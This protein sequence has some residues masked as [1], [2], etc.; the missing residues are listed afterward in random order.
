MSYEKSAG[1]IIYKVKRDGRRV[2]PF[3]LLLRYPGGY[4]EFARGHVEDGEREH[5]T[6]LR[7]IREETG[8][9]EL[10]FL[11]G[12]REKYRFHFKRS[13][14]SVAKDAVLY[15][16]EAT[17]WNVQVSEE[18]DGYVWA[19]YREAMVHL[20]FENAKQVL[21]KAQTFLNNRR[22]PARQQPVKGK[23]E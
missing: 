2:E 20:N 9:T 6:A 3:F 18:H 11:R 4:W 7:E 22:S 15:L 17:R 8:L 21:R 5:A 16:A 13:G 10:R 23:S 19:S 1:A 12:F 14:K